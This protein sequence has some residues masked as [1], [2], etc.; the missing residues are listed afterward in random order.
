MPRVIDLT[1]VSQT[2][3]LPVFKVPKWLKPKQ[4][5]ALIRG[6]L[7]DSETDEEEDQSE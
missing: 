1:T 5:E 2:D 3:L 7:S 6:N 4:I